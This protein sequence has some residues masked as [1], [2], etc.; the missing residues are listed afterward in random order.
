MKILLIASNRTEEPLPAFPL[1]VAY[2]AGN[3]DTKTH[4]VDVL[5]LMFKEDYKE[6]VTS[7]IGR[8]GGVGNIS[9]HARSPISIIGGWRLPAKP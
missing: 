5:D 6:S 9:G 8:A 4:S 7:A 2:L 1:G 3:I